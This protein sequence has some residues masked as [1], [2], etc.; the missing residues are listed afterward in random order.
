MRYG[1]R[2]YSLDKPPAA[3]RHKQQGQHEQ[4][5]VNTRQYVLDP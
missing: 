5:V 4:Q 2:G 1:K 3:A